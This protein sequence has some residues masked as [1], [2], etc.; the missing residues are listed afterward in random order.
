MNGSSRHLSRP[1]ARLVSIITPHFIPDETLT[2]ALKSGPASEALPLDVIR[3][4]KSISKLAQFAKR[5]LCSRKLLAADI[6]Y[7]ALFGRPVAHEVCARD[8]TDFDVRNAS[9]MDN[10]QAFYLQSFETDPDRL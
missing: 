6:R 3:P 7:C 5:G 9:I 1:F 4:S 2:L 10:A 8:D